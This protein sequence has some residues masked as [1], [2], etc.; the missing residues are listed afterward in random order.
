M[1]TYDGGIRSIVLPQARIVYL[2]TKG[3]TPEKQTMRLQFPDGFTYDYAVKAFNPLDHSIK[4]LEKKGMIIILPFYV[5]KMRE[6]VAKADGVGRKK[7]SAKMKTLLDKVDET[8]KD[9]REKGQIDGQDALDIIRNLDRLY[10]ELYGGYEEFVEDENMKEKFVRYSTQ[11][12]EQRS[13]E[14]A[15]NFLALDVSPQKV[16]QATGLSLRQIKAL[17]K[18]LKIEQ[19]A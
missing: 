15:K 10:A 9:C 5:M 17:L 1:K 14:I 12:L 11:I 6:D 16:A 4:E 13:L 3:K 2:T 18:T 8:V 7:L 19:P